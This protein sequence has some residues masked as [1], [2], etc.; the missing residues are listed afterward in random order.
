MCYLLNHII[1]IYNSIKSTSVGCIE[2]QEQN[3]KYSNLI[4]K[5]VNYRTSVLKKVAHD[6]KVKILW[7]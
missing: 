6:L 4:L 5:K 7:W 2:I 3:S 1:F